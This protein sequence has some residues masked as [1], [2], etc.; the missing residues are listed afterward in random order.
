MSGPGQKLGEW[1]ALEHVKTA[2]LLREVADLLELN[3]GA[4]IVSYDESIGP[5]LHGV[6]VTKNVRA[7]AT[8][9]VCEVD[10]RPVVI[11]IDRWAP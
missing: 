11:A 4:R 3:H 8:S 5:R 6:R 1:L 7:I 10:G 9:L 2:R